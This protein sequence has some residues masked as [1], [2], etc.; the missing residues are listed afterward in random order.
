MAPG[1][2]F[3]QLSLSRCMEQAGELG[4]SDEVREKFL[5]ANAQ[6]VFKL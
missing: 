2:N 3:P 5:R 4:L 1:S 6:R